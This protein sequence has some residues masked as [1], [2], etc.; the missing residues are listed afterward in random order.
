MPKLS[1]GTGKNPP[2]T[3]QLAHPS[4]IAVA[5]GMETLQ[6]SQYLGFSGVSVAGS[7]LLIDTWRSSKM[8]LMLQDEKF[9]S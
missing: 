9:D 7:P 1:V 8:M 2:A 4:L 3:N 5:G 6:V